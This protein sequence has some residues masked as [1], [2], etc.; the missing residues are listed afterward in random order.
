MHK[1]IVCMTNAFVPIP[2]ALVRLFISSSECCACA[3][4][5]T[6]EIEEKIKKKKKKRLTL[7]RGPKQRIMNRGEYN[8]CL[9]LA[10]AAERRRLSIFAAAALLCFF[11]SIHIRADTLPVRF[12]NTCIG[13]WI[14]PRSECTSHQSVRRAVKR[15]AY[16]AV[17][18]ALTTT[19]CRK[20][21]SAIL[22]IYYRTRQISVFILPFNVLLFLLSLYLIR[23]AA[24]VVAGEVRS[25][26]ATDTRPTV[27]IQL[28]E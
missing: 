8:F 28:I 5:K 20:K 18:L 10:E 9:L 27:D 14:S 22:W 16:A 6:T 13:H 17:E 4:K 24:Q 26:M 23:I 11:I 21:N 19:K 15:R 1:C 25:I 12:I 3:I 2:K 7:F